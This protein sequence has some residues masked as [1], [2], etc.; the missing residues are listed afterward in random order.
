VFNNKYSALH[1]M[2]S[3]EKSLASSLIG[4]MKRLVPPSDASIFSLDI[5]YTNPSLKA[6][7]QND[8]D[9]SHLEII[10]G[11][12]VMRHLYVMVSSGLSEFGQFQQDEF[13]LNSTAVLLS[14]PMGIKNLANEL[15][16]G[17]KTLHQFACGKGYLEASI[18]NELITIL[19]LIWREGFVKDYFEQHE[20]WSFHK[21]LG[22]AK[23]K[24][25][26]IYD[27]RSSGGDLKFAGELLPSGSCADPSFRLVLILDCISQ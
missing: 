2:T 20:R 7:S 5:D 25:K 16:I 8:V 13:K 9:C 27:E 18:F 1:S 23:E 6:P 22:L 26:T 15:G 10:G 12:D 19:G 4:R 14:H 3:Q 17:V 24:Y 21:V 11:D